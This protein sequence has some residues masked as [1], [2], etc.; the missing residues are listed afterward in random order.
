MFENYGTIGL[1]WK[2]DFHRL[3]ATYIRICKVNTQNEVLNGDHLQ[4]T[5]PWK[6]PATYTGN[7]ILKEL[8]F[9]SYIYSAGGSGIARPSGLSGLLD[10][11]KTKKKL[12]LSKQKVPFCS[13]LHYICHKE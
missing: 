8:Y 5:S 12:Q 6:Y 7:L 11:V 1:F 2:G 13:V 9:P 4:N 10:Q 3:A